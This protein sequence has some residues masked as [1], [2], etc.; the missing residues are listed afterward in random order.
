MGCKK[1]RTDSGRALKRT[2]AGLRGVSR[3]GDSR[4]WIL[5]EEKSEEAAADGEGNTFP[6]SLK[7][8]R[9]IRHPRSGVYDSEENGGPRS[10]AMQHSGL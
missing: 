6:Y 8:Q 5:D 10:F 2:W 4:C 1:P 7:S 9:R 3:K